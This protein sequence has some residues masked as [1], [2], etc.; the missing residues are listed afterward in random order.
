MQVLVSL[1][2]L[3]II[4]SWHY[5]PWLDIPHRPGGFHQWLASF[6]YTVISTPGD[7]IFMSSPEYR[8]LKK[9]P[10]F[11]VVSRPGNSKTSPL[12]FPSCSWENTLACGNSKCGCQLQAPW[13]CGSALPFRDKLE[14]RGR[15]EV[16]HSPI[17]RLTVG[18]G[19]A[20]MFDVTT[21]G[22]NR[23]QSLKETP[24]P[25][26]LSLQNKPTNTWVFSS[27]IRLL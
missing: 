17:S 22:P 11:L 2:S 14:I 24:S 26:I 25:L 23:R 20:A 4:A 10:C 27:Y 8:I 3:S 19:D 13:A 7:R 5:Q 16:F 21:R 18:V 15:E 9:G 12:R 1:L 6:L